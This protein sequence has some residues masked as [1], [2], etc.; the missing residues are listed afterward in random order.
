VVA[1][2]TQVP[3][4]TTTPPGT[5]KAAIASTNAASE[6]WAAVLAFEIGRGSI[7]R[8][9]VAAWITSAPPTITRS[10]NTTRITS[11]SGSI[12]RTTSDT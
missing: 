4:S 5:A 12:S 9:C 7:D 11:H 3:T 2:T 6:I 1:A 8:R 10:R